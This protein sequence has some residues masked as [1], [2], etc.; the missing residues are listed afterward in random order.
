MKLFLSCFAD[1]TLHKYASI[2]NDKRQLRV[3][4]SHD[5]YELFMVNCGSAVHKVNG[6]NQWVS[7]G[8]V[9]FVRPDDV[10]SYEHMSRDFEIINM[11][12]STATVWKVFQYLGDSFASSRLT[13]PRLPVV[14]QLAPNDYAM[15]VVQLEKLVLAKHRLGPR[16]DALYRFTLMSFIFHCFPPDPEDERPDMPVWLRG[17]CLEM[18]KRDNFTEGMPALRRLANSSAEHLARTFRRYLGTTP[19]DFVNNLRLEYAARTIASTKTKIVD[20]CESAG[21]DS[22]SHF[23]HLFGEKYGAPPNTFRKMAADPS[24]EHSMSDEPVLESGLPYGIPFMSS[25]GARLLQKNR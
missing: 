15:L 24:F 8:T 23:Y 17:L 10:H 21:F 12:V 6:A 22:L 13:E 5:Y 18:M 1:K 16:S 19:T 20:I 25:S 4:H 2:I 9:V 11:L 14:C 7:K 3:E